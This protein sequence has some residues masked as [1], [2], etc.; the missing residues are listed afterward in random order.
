LSGIF[1]FIDFFFR[2]ASFQT[3]LIKKKNIYTK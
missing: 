1:Q 2:F 3:I